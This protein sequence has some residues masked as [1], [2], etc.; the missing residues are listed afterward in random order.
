MPPD[1]PQ[2]AAT[3]AAA[4]R[5]LTFPLALPI[6]NRLLT[7]VQP[8][9][10]LP[11]KRIVG[12][13]DW[14]GQRALTKLFIGAGSKRHY[15][16]ERAGV[17]ALIAADIPTPQVITSGA[18][19]GGGYYLLTEFLA[20]AVSL[21]HVLATAP[22]SAATLARLQDACRL[23]GQLHA[24]GLEHHDPHPGN[25]LCHQGHVLIIDGDAVKRSPAPLAPASA[26]ANLALF[27]AQLPLRFEAQSGAL[28]DAYARPLPPAATLTALIAQARARR[29]ADYLKKTLRPCT[30]FD[31]WHTLRRFTA[32]VREQSAALASLLDDPERAIAA[33]TLLKN[34]NTATVARVALG[35]RQLV[36]KR[37]NLKNLVHA[38]SRAWRPSRAWHSWREGHRLSFLDIATPAPLALIEE[39]RPF[40]LG[41]LRARAWLISADVPAPSLAERLAALPADAPPPA[42][43]EALLTLMRTLHTHRIS[44]GDLK[45]SNLLWDGNQIVV[46]D[47][48]AMTQHTSATRYARAWRRDRARLLANWPEGSELHQWLDRNLPEGRAP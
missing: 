39:R 32:V 43:A 9:R 48:D 45:A 17:D 5:E 31:V 42:E 16:R 23:I 3:L 27:L 46:I 34:G 7:L 22:A 18:F 33:G 21:A 19:A 30:L 8:L 40:S 2:D 4:G 13:G 47:L 25:F 38:F 14:A 15:Q 12:E 37:Y 36:I 11:G 41:L 6:E 29:L 28:L 35:E 1:T 20:D 24:N 44:H 10:V 26:H